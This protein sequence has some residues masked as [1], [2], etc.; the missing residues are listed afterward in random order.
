MEYLASLLAAGNVA[1][2]RKALARQLAVRRYRRSVRVEGEPD[3][4][5]L[6]EARLTVEDAK[7]MHRLLA[8]A[9]YHER[10]VVPTA[11]VEKTAST[12]YIE[13]GYAGFAEFAADKGPKRRTTFHGQGEGVER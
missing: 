3:V 5:V 12:A 13:R 1:E 9:H 8:L 2:V 4:S 11:R 6:E 7:H 10:F